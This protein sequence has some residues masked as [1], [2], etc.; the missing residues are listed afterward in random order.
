MVLIILS[1]SHHRNVFHPPSTCGVPHVGE[2]LADFSTD[3]KIGR[4]QMDLF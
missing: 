1:D 4:L 3:T 2:L